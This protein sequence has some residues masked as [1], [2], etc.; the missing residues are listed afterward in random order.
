MELYLYYPVFLYGTDRRIF[1]KCA[2]F[3]R[4]TRFDAQF[5]L[6]S[7]LYIVL[8]ELT[9]ALVVLSLSVFLSHLY[10]F[11]FEYKLL[12]LFS[13]ACGELVTA[14]GLSIILTI[15]ISKFVLLFFC[16]GTPC[17]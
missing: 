17:I 4:R 6:S 8:L 7:W 15:V 5:P 1:T 12:F 2:Q 3:S 16:F 13:I 14:T 9:C 10:K 11:R